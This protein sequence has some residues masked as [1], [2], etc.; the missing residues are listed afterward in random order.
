MPTRHIVERRR[1]DGSSRRRSTRRATARR[2]CTFD[3][4]CGSNRQ[5]IAARSV[6]AEFRRRDDRRDVVFEPRSH[7]A[8]ARISEA[9]DVWRSGRPARLGGRDWIGRASLTHERSRIAGARSTSS[10]QPWSISLRPACRGRSSCRTRRS[11]MSSDL[12]VHGGTGSGASSGA[13][14]CGCRGCHLCEV[15]SGAAPRAG[16]RRQG[17]S[18]DCRATSVGCTT[19]CASD[20]FCGRRRTVIRQAAS[21]STGRGRHLR[22]AAAG[23]SAWRRGDDEGRTRRRHAG[24]LRR[25]GEGHQSCRPQRR[26]AR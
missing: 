6:I 7:T 5:A 14:G 1:V 17:P 16:G 4:T 26:R 13:I 23:S 21:I 18:V 22:H 3:Q 12:R 19:A 24:S 11:R 9:S 10:R 20:G 2:P 15:D 8:C 25:E